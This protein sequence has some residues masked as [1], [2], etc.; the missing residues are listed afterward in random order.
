M[1]C[2][3]GYYLF[4]NAP[5]SHYR[6]FIALY[7]ICVIILIAH[8]YLQMGEFV[9]IGELSKRTAQRV[10]PYDPNAFGRSLV[11]ALTMVISLCFCARRKVVWLVFS[12]LLVG[13]CLPLLMIAGS[14]SS[15]LVL[16]CICL[17]IAC[18]HLWSKER[19]SALRVIGVFGICLLCGVVV[20]SFSK[21]LLPTN[22]S[23]R[24]TT[25]VY[26][27]LSSFA[28]NIRVDF[29]DQGLMLAESAPVFGLGIRGYE[30]VMQYPHNVLMEVL[31][32]SGVIGLVCFLLGVAVLIVRCTGLLRYS[33]NY[34]PEWYS[35]V[36]VMVFSVASSWMFALLIGELSDH[37]VSY[38]ILS[39]LLG[40]D[41]RIR[42]TAFG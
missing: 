40:L 17:L 7:I 20:F 15:I 38:F 6:H 37:R 18:T 19:G 10:F 4:K 26:E 34:L 31:I 39:V 2:A 13:A 36:F 3:M 16:F 25:L 1:V 28:G 33:R 11:V 8:M 21:E 32:E 35:V 14:R 30:S 9:R 5:I 41:H 24:L 29:L 22:L 23:Y 42:T 12:V 27:P